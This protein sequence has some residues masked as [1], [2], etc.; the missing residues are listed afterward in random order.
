MPFTPP[1]H[2]SDGVIYDS[3]G[4]KVKLWGVNYYAP[5]NHNFYNIEELGKDHFAAVD[6]DIRH[7]R[8]MGVDLIRMH[9]YEREIT[10][11]N[12]NIVENRNLE[13][14]DYLVDQC[15]KNGIFLMLAPMVWWNT[16]NNQMLQERYYAYW[17]IGSQ[18]AFGFSNFYSCDAMLWD[19]DAIACQQRY[20]EGL[21][22][23]RN[24]Q[25]GK[26]LS[27]YSNVVAF[28]LFNEPRYPAL[29][30]MEK[31]AEIGP[32]KMGNA[33]YSRG[34]QRLKLLKMWEDFRAAHPGESDPEACF[35][36]FRAEV[37]RT[38][39]AALFPIIDKYFGDKVLKTHFTSYRGTPPPELADVCRNA[40]VQAYT[41]G[42]YLNVNSFDAENTDSADHL[43]LCKAWFDRLDGVDFG[44]FA[45]IAYEFDATATQN[46][47]P[48]AAIAAMYAKHDV[49]MASYFTYTPAAVA[50][51]NPGW[52]V[53]FL[54]LEHTPAR[55]A[56]FAAAGEIFRHHN[57]DDPI[58]LEDQAWHGSDYAIERRNDFVY[59]KGETVFRYSNSND[60]ELE[61]VSTLEL[62]SGRGNSRFA[63][64]DGNGFYLL[65]KI[66]S[67]HWRLTLFPRQQ[68]VMA[69]ERGKAYRPMANRYVNCLKEPPVSILK[70]QRV[71]FRLNAFT[72]TEAAC[73]LGGC[74]IEVGAG[75]ELCIQAGTYL[76]TVAS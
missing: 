64:C 27:D 24:T 60:I 56:G 71:H 34:D 26:R 33:T 46:G 11:R 15:E 67:A 36:L 51:W 41:I 12:G 53:H 35:V 75:G 9:L 61:D 31:D 4:A 10:D 70:E 68:F 63:S 55:A 52:L 48:L 21:F 43:A 73:A 25:S 54:S 3:T 65:E 39:F 45:R 74:P 50:A 58:T 66:D 14:F 29:W 2:V 59:F 40:G 13:V 7:F 32:D 22:S 1:F 47:Y 37:L 16:I 42:T 28:E 6:E 8:M 23:R 69:P 19:P 57:P 5:F 38:Y 44:G 72:I 30:F 18:N 62:V 49:Q 76:L 17:Y 20:M